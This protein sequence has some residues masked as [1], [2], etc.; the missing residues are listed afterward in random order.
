MAGGFGK[1]VPEQ[2]AKCENAKLTMDTQDGQDKEKKSVY[3][4]HP[5]SMHFV[6]NLS[7]KRLASIFEEIAWQSTRYSALSAIGR[8]ADE[9]AGGGGP[10]AGARPRGSPD[11]R[12][13]R[14]R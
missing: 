3:P 6:W 4:V 10:D 12:A 13:A 8:R 11:G 1:G 2:R 9:R 14:G 5:C 7:R